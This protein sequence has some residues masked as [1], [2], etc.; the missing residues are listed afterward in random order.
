M[1]DHPIIDVPITP[2]PA[3]LCW[4]EQKDPAKPHMLT[5]CMFRKGHKG[6]HQWEVDSEQR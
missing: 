2:G 1:A 4:A 5:N 6:K 3:G